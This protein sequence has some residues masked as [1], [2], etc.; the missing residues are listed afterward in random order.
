MCILQELKNKR[1]RDNRALLDRAAKEI[2]RLQKEN[3]RL[4]ESQEPPKKISVQ[5]VSGRLTAEIGGD[6]NYPEIFVYL[7][8]IDGVEI[9]LVA[10]GEDTK[11]KEDVKAYLYGD[12]SR[13]DYSKSYTWHKKDL[14]IEA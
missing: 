13:D 6:P 11:N 3:E 8:R 9:D 5:A 2:E 10:V 14:D 7:E 4:R 12:T 1:S